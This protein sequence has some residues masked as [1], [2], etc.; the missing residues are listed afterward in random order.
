M[1]SWLK[2]KLCPSLFQEQ[3]WF[4]CVGL[5]H[6]TEI[7]QRKPKLEDEDMPYYNC[8]SHNKLVQIL[9]L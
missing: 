8:P 7:I 3:Q 9:K 1:S 4:S 2:A 6:R 5:S